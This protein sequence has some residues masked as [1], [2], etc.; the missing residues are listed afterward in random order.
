MKL[1]VVGG[2]SIGERHLRNLHRLEAGS[3]ALVEPVETRRAALINECRA[4]GFSSLEEGLAWQPDCA[5]I[6]APTNLHVPHALHAARAGCHLFIEKPLSHSRA[7]IGELLSEVERRGLITMVGCNMRYHPGPAA[8]KALLDE[9]VVGQVLA[10]R[11][12][13]GSY[14]PRWRPEQAYRGS[15]SASSEQGGAILDCIHEIDLA[16]WC[17]GPARLLAAATLPAVS[18]GLETDGLAEILLRHDC[19]VLASV[20]LNFVQRDVS[21]GIQVIGTEG[22]MYW[23]FAQKRVALYGCDGQLA[24]VFPQPEGWQLNQMYLDEMADYLQA[25]R[26]R[27]STVNPLAGGLAALDIALAAREQGRA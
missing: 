15:Y 11:L 6:A 16:L 7:R 8:V 12:Y 2:G 26:L 25:V 19:G 14:L 4:L 27:Q 23:D 21:R 13:T 5:V 10:A 18:L 24:R 17:F 3:L 22:T 20:H 9:G 1:L